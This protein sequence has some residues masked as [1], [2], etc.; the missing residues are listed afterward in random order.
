[1]M[2]TNEPQVL[3]LTN[4]ATL[5]HQ[6]LEGYREPSAMFGKHQRSVSRLLKTLSPEQPTLP[7]KAIAK[8]QKWRLDT[9]AERTK[10]KPGYE[11]I[12]AVAARIER[13]PPPPGIV[14]AFF[15]GMW[16]QPASVLPHTRRFADKLDHLAQ[17]LV[18][19][20]RPDQEPS[21]AGYKQ[22]LLGSPLVKREFW[23]EPVH[24]YDYRPRFEQ[25]ADW[26]EA[27]KLTHIIIFHLQISLLALWDAEYCANTFRRVTTIP[28]F[29]NLAPRRRPRC[30][31]QPQAGLLRIN[32]RKADVVDGPF[33]QLI[34]LLWCLLRFVEDGDWPQKFPTLDEMGKDLNCYQG[35]LAQLRAGNPNLTADLLYTLWPNTLRDK[36]GEPMFP[37]L[38]LLAVAHLWDLINPSGRPL[39]PVDQCYMRAWNCH[40]HALG[41]SQSQ[42]LSP[43][44]SWPG[45]LNR[46]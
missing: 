16:G 17:A 39:I 23:I 29:L 2:S 13:T 28:L 37:P 25:A 27:W 18:T 40:R 46:G 36:T 10:N 12:E 22:T 35:D 5:L 41:T 30:G 24:N 4:W 19:Q 14:L 45:Y 31:D 11:P 1:M 34:D 6:R 15:M 32:D 43:T 9:I 44:I 20:Q 7:P 8:A 38:T 33:S 3:G 26:Q 21:L 42:A